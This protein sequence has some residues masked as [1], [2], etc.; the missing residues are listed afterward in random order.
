MTTL[1]DFV[2]RGRAAA[3]SGDPLAAAT[4]LMAELLANPHALDVPHLPDDET[5]LYEDASVSLWHERFLPTEILPPHDHAYP[6]VLG[7]Y[8]GRERNHLA[9]VVDGR[10]VPGGT[11]DLEAG[12]FHVFGPRDVHAVQALDGAPSL[13]L[14]IY[15]GALT[16]V[17]RS[18]YDWDTG[19]PL[20]MTGP[21]FEA[22]KR[23]A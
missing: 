14:H 7:V 6:A 19:A 21:A 12:R 15:L 4:A 8:R 16:Q 18:L 22:M 23:P 9:H 13:G 17:E 10:A 2:A 5:L 20:R 11:L 3:A 1:D